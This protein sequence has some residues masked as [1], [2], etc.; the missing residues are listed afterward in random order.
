MK[1]TPL[2]GKVARLEAVIVPVI[3]NIGTKKIFSK[4]HDC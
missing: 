3:D 4:V 2:I 1:L